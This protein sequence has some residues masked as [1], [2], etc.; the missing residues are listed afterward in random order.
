M[1][2]PWDI[3]RFRTRRAQH[4]ENLG[5]HGRQAREPG[6]DACVLREGHGFFSKHLSSMASA[7]IADTALNIRPHLLRASHGLFE[8]LAGDGVDA[9]VWRG[10]NCLMPLL[11]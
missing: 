7:A 5:H 3:G 9:R 4:H 6:S 11:L 8:P 10:G 1:Y 2:D